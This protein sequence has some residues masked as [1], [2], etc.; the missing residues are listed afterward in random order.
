[1]ALARASRAHP[2]AC[3]EN[4]RIPKFN[5]NDRGSSP[6]VRGKRWEEDRWTDPVGLIPACAGKMSGKAP[7]RNHGSAHPRACGEN[8]K[9]MAPDKWCAGS[10]PRVRG[11]LD[12]TQC[13]DLLGGLIPA[14]AGKTFTRQSSRWQ[15]WAHPRACGEN[16]YAQTASANRAGSSPR[17]RGKRAAGGTHFARTRLIPARAG[18]TPSALMI[19]RPTRAHPRACGENAERCGLVGD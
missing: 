11:K 9:M 19:W 8:A 7:S 2:R 5:L 17:V 4:P 14:R 10:S 6:R 3:G 18:K 15:E 13:R 16:R 12:Q 1:M